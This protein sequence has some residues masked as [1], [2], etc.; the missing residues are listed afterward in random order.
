MQT[1]TDIQRNVNEGLTEIHEGRP[2]IAYREVAYREGGHGPDRYVV[3]AGSGDAPTQQQMKRAHKLL[4]KAYGNLR[5]FR[6]QKARELGFVSE[7]P[8]TSSW[9]Y[10]FNVRK[11]GADAEARS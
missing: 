10:Y 9:Q 3:D 8:W 2:T 4:Q 5:A 6:N 1:A 7:N 11:V